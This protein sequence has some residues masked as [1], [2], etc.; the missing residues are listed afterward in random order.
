[1]MFTMTSAGGAL[2]PTLPGSFSIKWLTTLVAVGKGIMSGLVARPR[3]HAGDEP[4]SLP[5][6]ES[7]EGPAKE[8][9]GSPRAIFKPFALWS[10]C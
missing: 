2:S 5:C 10:A 1:M 3:G 4:C 6:S 8:L 7:T 9:R